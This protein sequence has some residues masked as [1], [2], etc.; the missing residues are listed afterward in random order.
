MASAG[1]EARALGIAALANGWPL[2]W[3]L[4]ALLGAAFVVAFVAFGADE[5]G[6]G[7]LVRA[8][9]RISFALFLPVYAAS[10]LRRL[11]PT[12]ATRWLLRNRRYLGVAFAWAH[13]L[14]ALAITCLATLLGAGF[15]ADAATLV[16]GGLGYA[17][18]A[19]MVATSF[20]GSAR[21]L[22]P[23]R[24]AL[25]HRTGIHWLWVVFAIS[26]TGRVAEGPGYA[27]PAALVWGAAALR[28]AA[29]RR[30]VRRDRGRPTLPR[31]PH[32]PPAG[33]KAA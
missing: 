19:A 9:A 12:P 18:L 13:G 26:W 27:L 29:Q 24:W 8:T 10:S 28:L 22:G 11:W 4:A 21:R 25:L 17:L 15:R 33:G 6:L 23:R 3:A 14:H 1:T 16:G 7:A 2:F 32:P 5:Q 31:V 30:G 20:D